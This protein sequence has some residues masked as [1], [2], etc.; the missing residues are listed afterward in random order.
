MNTYSITTKLTEDF[1]P[2]WLYFIDGVLYVQKGFK[3]EADAF[4]AG[5]EK[6]KELKKGR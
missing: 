4:N 3:T 5:L 2:V 1:Q 6:V